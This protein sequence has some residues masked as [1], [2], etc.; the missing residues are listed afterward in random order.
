M[1]AFAQGLTT[2][3]QP[4]GA[5]NRCENVSERSVPAKWDDLATITRHGRRHPV[6]R[7]PRFDVP[8]S[9]RSGKARAH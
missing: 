9:I 7:P 6:E 4:K 5:A 2:L 3:S 8:Q 1:E